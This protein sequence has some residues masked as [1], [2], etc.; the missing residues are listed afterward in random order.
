[1]C[2]INPDLDAEYVR[3]VSAAVFKASSA[4]DVDAIIEYIKAGVRS[5]FLRR[6]VEHARGI[7]ENKA[8]S[9]Y[10]LARGYIYVAYLSKMI[11]AAVEGITASPYASG[12]YYAPAVCCQA[13][14]A[15]KSAWLHFTATTNIA[16]RDA[17]RAWLSAVVYE[18]PCRVPA[19]TVMALRNMQDY[20]MALALD[21]SL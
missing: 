8:A 17:A 5:E 7:D 21:A 15:I 3:Q 18:Y 1:M 11:D 16:L 4:E 14:N 2:R 12:W 10:A 20:L 9:L 13:L 19:A 6:I